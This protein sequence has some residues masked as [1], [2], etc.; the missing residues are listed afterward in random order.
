MS[1]LML[2]AKTN[3]VLVDAMVKQRTEV[4]R[5]QRLAVCQAWCEEGLVG[6]RKSEKSRY[7]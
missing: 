6:H 7:H 3:A 5:M 2:Q 1:L 4:D